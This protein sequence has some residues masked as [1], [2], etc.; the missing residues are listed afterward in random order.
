MMNQH[1]YSDVLHYVQQY[2]V[3]KVRMHMHTCMLVAST[4][5]INMLVL[6]K[7]TDECQG[8]I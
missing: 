3:F 5:R 2:G 6:K 1:K 4:L 7:L 8:P